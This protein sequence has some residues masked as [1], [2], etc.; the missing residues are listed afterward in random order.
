MKCGVMAYQYSA[1]PA[2]RKLRHADMA[3]YI[4]KR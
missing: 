2:R 4:C 3:S 1:K